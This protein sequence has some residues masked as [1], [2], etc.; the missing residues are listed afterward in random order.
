MTSE[1]VFD[2]D[3]NSKNAAISISTL[4]KGAGSYDDV[5]EHS[6]QIFYILQGTMN[7]YAE[8]KFLYSVSA[9]DAILIEAGDIH[10]VLNE[11]DEDCIFYSVTTPPILNRM[12]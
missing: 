9:G 6:D 1:M 2:P 10:A 12:K 11:E 3:S 4:K 5:H 8:N 7:V